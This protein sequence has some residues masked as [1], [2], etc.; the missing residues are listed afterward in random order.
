M[1]H[2]TYL[3]ILI[4]VLNLS[5]MAGWSSCEGLNIFFSNDNLLSLDTVEPDLYSDENLF[6]NEVG[7]NIGD[8][9][10]TDDDDDDGF[11][12]AEEPFPIDSIPNDFSVTNNDPPNCFSSSSLSRRRI[13]TRSSVAE[14]N[15]GVCPAS[16]SGSSGST[17]SNSHDTPGKYLDVQTDEDVQKYWCSESDHVGFSNIPVCNILPLRGIPS[18]KLLHQDLKSVALPVGFLTLAVVRISKFF[19]L[20][21]LYLHF[22]EKE[23]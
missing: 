15:N 12:T 7:S 20:K 18:D 21:S 1:W 10:L 23:I 6:T 11:L 3:L 17:G 4:L 19:F 14:E 9:T 2:A 13:R 8:N 5:L 16:Q 22:F